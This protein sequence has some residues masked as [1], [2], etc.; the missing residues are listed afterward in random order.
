MA[1]ADDQRSS[2]LG[3]LSLIPAPPPDR[4]RRSERVFRRDRAHVKALR[5]WQTWVAFVNVW[6]CYSCGQYVGLSPFAEWPLRRLVEF[7]SILIGVV[8]LEVI[9]ATAGAA[10]LWKEV[11]DRES[12]NQSLQRDG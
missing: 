6:V 4:L 3:S 8:L 1:Y 2:W 5:R 10:S 11:L 7:A 9:V 12:A